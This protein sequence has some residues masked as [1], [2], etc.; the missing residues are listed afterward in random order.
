M[1]LSDKRLIV[2]L[3]VEIEDISLPRQLLFRTA[4]IP[5]LKPNGVGLNRH[6]RTTWYLQ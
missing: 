2:Q 3:L 5:F 4:S 1:T 6:M